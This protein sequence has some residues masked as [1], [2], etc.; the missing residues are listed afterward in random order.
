MIKLSAFIVLTVAQRLSINSCKYMQHV[1]T[2]AHRSLNNPCV[3][4]ER[5]RGPLRLSVPTQHD[6]STAGAH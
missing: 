6:L 3:H 4:G 2:A 1:Q 5:E